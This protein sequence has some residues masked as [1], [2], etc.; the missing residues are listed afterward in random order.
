MIASAATPSFADRPRSSRYAGRWVAMKASWKPQAK[1]PRLSSQKPPMAERLA[2]R[3][4][5]PG[6]ALVHRGV[7]R[8]GPGPVRQGQG[9]RHQH[10][11][12]DRERDERT[13]PA[14]SVD[15]ALRGRHHRELAEPADGARQAEGPAAALGYDEAAERAVDRAEGAARQADA[16][17]YARA[18]QEGG[19]RRGVRHQ[20]EA[21]GIEEEAARDDLRR[22]EAVGDHP[23]EGLRDAPHEVLQ[24]DGQA[25]GLARPAAVQAH[26]QQEE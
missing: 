15:Q 18:P 3:V 16:D 4:G 14:E 10:R 25:E 11:A 1:N 12:P 8:L 19:R 2:D 5:E 23:G 21:E 20:H 6:G 7:G 22:A 13:V 9:E 26:G 24:P 17:A